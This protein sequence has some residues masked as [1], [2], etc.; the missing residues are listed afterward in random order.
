MKTMKL[1]AG[2]ERRGPRSSGRVFAEGPGA[3]KTIGKKAETMGYRQSYAAESPSL[4]ANYVRSATRETYRKRKYVWTDTWMMNS[5]PGGH[6]RSPGRITS[7]MRVYESLE[8]A[9]NCK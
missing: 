1:P 9:C 3:I 5:L 7:R 2:D 6:W 4:R 8:V